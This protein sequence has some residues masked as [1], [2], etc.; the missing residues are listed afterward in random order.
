MAASGS[1]APRTRQALVNTGQ[2]GVWEQ[3]EGRCEWAGDRV[4]VTV[5]G[6]LE[7]PVVLQL[8]AETRLWPG[9][10]QAVETTRKGCI[11]NNQAPLM[12]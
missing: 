7:R 2:K 10:K 12:S 11:C 3:E 1:A 8:C 4:A 6:V 5:Q 9:Q